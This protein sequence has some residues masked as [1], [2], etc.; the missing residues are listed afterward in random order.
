MPSFD[1]YQVIILIFNYTIDFLYYSDCS[2]GVNLPYIVFTLA[3]IYMLFTPIL[4]AEE[5]L[6]VG[7]SG[8]NAVGR[9]EVYALAHAF[10]LRNPKVK[11]TFVVNEGE[12]YKKTL[13]K[14]L[15]QEEGGL[16]VAFWMAGERFDKY[17][18]LNLVTPVTDIWR[19]NKLAEQFTPHL[20]R[21]VALDE[22]F[23]AVPFSYY[24]WGFFYNKQLFERLGLALPR[25]WQEF[26]KILSILKHEGLMP[27]SI[28][29]KYS[30]SVSPWFELFN[31]RLNGYNFNQSFIKG[32]VSA[33][34]PEIRHVFEYWQKLIQSGYF[35]DH[36]ESLIA[37]LPLLYREQ[38]GIILGGSYFASFF[39][40]SLSNR[41]GFIPFPVMN[42]DVDKSEVAPVDI[43]FIAQRSKKKQLAKRFL[44]FL[45]SKEA[46]ERFNNKTHFLSANKLADISN[47]DTLQSVKRSLNGVSRL[48]LFFDREAEDTFAKENM[49]IWRDFITDPDIE[50]TI[51]KMEKVRVNYLSRR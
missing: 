30:W 13:Q 22:Q 19:S 2:G 42:L 6:K 46:Q 1:L 48:T 32:N 35:I 11:V 9:E 8:I 18:R 7:I 37:S 21:A 38:A 5:V 41:I 34:S 26:I 14:Q 40:K 28:G 36:K 24:Q 47:S 16:D 33:N 25:D 20:N 15:E 45:S 27:I 17:I 4:K 3:F 51:S 29:T 43:A 23:Y 31:L 49:A 44:V 39:P 12:T 50:E 10:E